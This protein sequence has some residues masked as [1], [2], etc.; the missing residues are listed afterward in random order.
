MI[1]ISHVV[2]VALLW[3]ISV[4]ATAS[5]SAYTCQVSHV[6][7]LEKN[8]AL[9]TFPDSKLEKIMKENSFS[10]SRET[11]ALIGSSASL[12]T[13]LAKSTR[14]INK[15]SKENSFEA[16]ADFGDFENGNHPFQF[17]EVEEFNNGADKPFVLM[18]ALGI[19]TGVCK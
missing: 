10:V 14:V 18:G 9:K 5:E 13:S 17:L 3:S 19:V 15:G 16:I 11:G 1:R 7:S 4:T 6:Y 12:D 8:G 2:F